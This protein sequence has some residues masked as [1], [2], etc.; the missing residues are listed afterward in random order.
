MKKRLITIVA[1]FAFAFTLNAFAAKEKTEGTKLDK[2]FAG[3]TSMT[4][5]QVKELKGKYGYGEMM[6]MSEISK[7]SGKPME[8]VMADR[9]SGMGWGKISKKY[10]INLGEVISASKKNLKSMKDDF[11]DES[12]YKKA[13]K[14][15]KKASKYMDS[16]DKIKKK[17]KKDKKG[18]KSKKSK[19]DKKNR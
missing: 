3:K 2:T 14:E 16:K 8:D 19:K 17:S 6:I 5:E 10:D 4:E 13:R 1:L 15:V 18:K 9:S 7:K 12:E 11:G